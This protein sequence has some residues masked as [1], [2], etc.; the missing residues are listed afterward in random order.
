MNSQLENM[1]HINI[2]VT[3]VEGFT[4]NNATTAPNENPANKLE[5]LSSEV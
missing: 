5:I 1:L 4:N 3:I 2:I